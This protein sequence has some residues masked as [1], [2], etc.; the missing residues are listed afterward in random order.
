MT[1]KTQ[2]DDSRPEIRRR[3]SGASRRFSWVRGNRANFDFRNSDLY[4][5]RV[6]GPINDRMAS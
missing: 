3:F 2:L 4:C 1:S 6:L 5:F